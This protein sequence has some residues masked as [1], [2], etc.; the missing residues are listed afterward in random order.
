MINGASSRCAPYFS[1]NDQKCIVTR[2]PI[3][4]NT[5][6]EALDELENQLII[7]SVR[8]FERSEILRVFT[9]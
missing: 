8:W 1:L 6:G 9:T 7:P 4:S 3:K 5:L 2:K